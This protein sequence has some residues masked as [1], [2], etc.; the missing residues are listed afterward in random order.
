MMQANE[1][2]HPARQCPLLQVESGSGLVEYAIV[3][4]VLMTMLLGIADFS[5]AVYAYHFVSN[6]ARDAARYA[7]VRG[8]TCG[9]PPVGDCSCSCSGFYTA[10]GVAGPFTTQAAQTTDIKDFVKNVPT[11]IDPTQLT[12][13][14]S[15]PNPKS[16]TTCATT[17]NAP[18]CTVVVQVSYT[19][20]FL[21]SFVSKKSV[22]L[23]ST[24]Q[25]IITH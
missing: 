16:L 22:T 17:F 19:F 11:G 14:P 1:N 20:N 7:S 8:S 3:F 15:W 6:A 4:V 12:T 25:E 5:R 21:S 10:S 24:S 13:T 18:G 9:A 23:T 2:S